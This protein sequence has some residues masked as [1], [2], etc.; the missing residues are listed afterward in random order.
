MASMN[1]SVLPIHILCIRCFHI[2]ETIEATSMRW[3]MKFVIFWL[4]LRT[5]W[6]TEKCQVIWKQTNWPTREH[7][8]EWKLCVQKMPQFRPPWVVKWYIPPVSYTHL[9]VYKRQVNKSFWLQKYLT[10]AKIHEF[11]TILNTRYTKKLIS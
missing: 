3:V 1:V 9:D 6:C 4:R 11:I 5:E 2:R 7:R 8:N 10:T